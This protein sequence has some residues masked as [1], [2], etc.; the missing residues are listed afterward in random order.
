M[1]VFTR[2]ESTRLGNNN[3]KTL[4]TPGQ[5]QTLHSSRGIDRTLGG[6]EGNLYTEG[7]IGFRGKLARPKQQ[8]STSRALPVTRVRQQF[9]QTTYKYFQ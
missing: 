2:A 1:T 5:I 9:S 4:S 8:S 3:R 7:S 6:E